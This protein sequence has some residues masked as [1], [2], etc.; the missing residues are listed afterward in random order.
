MLV[1]DLTLSVLTMGPV[2]A[3]RYSHIVFSGHTCF[4]KVRSVEQPHICFM[5]NHR[6]IF[7]YSATWVLNCSSCS[8]NDAL[9][10]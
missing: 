7:N 4:M 5:W 6:S 10:S 3:G 9:S 1:H 2:E 8:S